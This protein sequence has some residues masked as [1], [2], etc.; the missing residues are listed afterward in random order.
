[1]NKITQFWVVCT[2]NHEQYINDSYKNCFFLFKT[3]IK[4]NRL[5]QKQ[6]LSTHFK[7]SSE[8]YPSLMLY[9]KKLGEASRFASGDKMGGGFPFVAMLN[10][11]DK[12]MVDINAIK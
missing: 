9:P 3:E 1:M 7:V 2:G 6:N 5:D 12:V 11:L 4:N 10:P 8:P